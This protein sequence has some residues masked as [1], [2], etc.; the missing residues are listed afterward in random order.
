MAQGAAELAIRALK[1]GDDLKISLGDRAFTPLKTFLCRHATPY[2]ARSLARTYVLV[3]AECLETTARVW[4][5]VTL[6][7]SE[8]QTCDRVRPP[9]DVHWPSGYSVPAVKLARM[10]VDK[11]M[12]GQGLGSQLVD[13]AIAISVSISEHVGCRLLVTDAKQSAV[14]FYEKAGFTMLDT[15]GNLEKSAPA[16]F[17]ELPKLK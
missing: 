1:P 16:M 9:Q 15:P 10:A 14:K 4:G 13:F 17:V 3:D 7:A 5:Y 2:E 6:V 12:R 11:S 8:V